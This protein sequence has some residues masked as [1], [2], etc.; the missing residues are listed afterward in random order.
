MATTR[1][2]Q[3]GVG[4]SPYGT[5]Q[6]KVAAIEQPAQAKGGRVRKRQRYA[7]QLEGEWLA[8]SSIEELY[9][10]LDS[11][12]EKELENVEEKVEKVVQRVIRTGKSAPK[13]DLI[14]VSKTQ[15]T[16]VR[17]AISAINAELERTYWRR[18]AE[19]LAARADDAEIELLL[20]VI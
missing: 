10:Y 2:G 1:L 13:P 3:F 9:E 17:E 14:K 4:L 20:E 15:D 8:F 6:P 18:V 12:K 11:L 16:E 7:F 19:E 5:F